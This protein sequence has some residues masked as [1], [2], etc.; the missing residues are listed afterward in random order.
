MEKQDEKIFTTLHF[1]EHMLDCEGDLVYKAA[2]YNQENEELGE[3]KA[4]Q[5]ETM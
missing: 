2:Y 4:V 1:N 3:P 5:V